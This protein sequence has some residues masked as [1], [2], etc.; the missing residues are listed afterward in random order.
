MI[1]RSVTAVSAA[2]REVSCWPE[3]IMSV[4]CFRSSSLS[5][6][7]GAYSPDC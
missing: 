5:P 1:A 6:L 3:V 7:A 2:D 4:T